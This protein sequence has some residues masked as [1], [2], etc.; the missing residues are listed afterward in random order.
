M[1]NRSFIL[2]PAAILAFSSL[3]TLGGCSSSN[4]PTD[5]AGGTGGTGS[6]G[7]PGSGG[8]APATGGSGASG[9]SAG[10][11][12]GSGNSG[13]SGG[14]SG[15][16]TA[17]MQPVPTVPNCNV[18]ATLSNTCATF[19]CHKGPYASA[20]LEL[21]PDMGFVGRVKDVT[22]THS[23]IICADTGLTCA[24][25]PAACPTGDKIIDS[26]TPANSWMLH[27]IQGTQNGCG[28]PMPAPS[29]NL[30]LSDADKQCLAT[31][32]TE[33]AALPK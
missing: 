24:T 19:G 7:M 21:T 11:A 3:I 12:A 9:G 26:A 17:A 32:I 15:S 2:A 8:S 16:G 28:D 27:K 10:A 18:G 33:I 1:F 22:A 31:L 30:S 23:Q 13:N 5:S 4:E 6:A 29:S 20:G 14:S 25:I